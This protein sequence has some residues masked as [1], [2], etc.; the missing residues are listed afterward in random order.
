MPTQLA[1]RSASTV[2]DASWRFDVAGHDGRP[3]VFSL[4]V[5][6]DRQQQIC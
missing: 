1:W 3:D 6:R 5:N 4:T 2:D